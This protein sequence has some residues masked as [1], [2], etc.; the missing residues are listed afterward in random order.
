[1]EICGSYHL[2]SGLCIASVNIKDG[3]MGTNLGPADG[4]TEQ[5]FR[6]AWQAFYETFEEHA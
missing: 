6:D 2:N 1:M 3:A 5:A 4:A